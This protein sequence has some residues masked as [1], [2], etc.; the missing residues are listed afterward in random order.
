LDLDVQFSVEGGC[1]FS[2]RK[3]RN[4]DYIGEGGW[5]KVWKEW[6]EGKW[7]GMCCMREE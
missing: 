7:V 3:C 5:E 6:R 1:S 2:K 4:S